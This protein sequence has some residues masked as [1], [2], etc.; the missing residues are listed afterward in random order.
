MQTAAGR[1]LFVAFFNQTWRGT[2]NFATAEYSCQWYPRKVL[3]E[4]RAN[5]VAAFKEWVTAPTTWENKPSKNFLLNVNRN[6]PLV[7]TIVGTSILLQA[8]EIYRGIITI[9]TV[10]LEVITSSDVKTINIKAT[11]TSPVNSQKTQRH[12]LKKE[13]C[14]KEL[15]HCNTSQVTVKE[16]PITQLFI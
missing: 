6:S 16:T 4:W 3:Y 2:N 10:E 15:V 11:F 9:W 12:Y 14:N 1:L 8:F 7:M 5:K 13:E